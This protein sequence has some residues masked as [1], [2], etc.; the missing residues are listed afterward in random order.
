MQSRRSHPSW[1]SGTT[2]STALASRSLP[3]YE[4]NTKKQEGADTTTVVWRPTLLRFVPP[5][6]AA[7]VCMAQQHACSVHAALKT[8][9]GLLAC[10]MRP[11]NNPKTE[12]PCHPQTPHAPLR[13]YGRK[14]ELESLSDC[15]MNCWRTRQPATKRD[16]CLDA[17]SLLSANQP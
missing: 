9:S 1:C 6:L 3:C 5:W 13:P 17:L 4:T 12:R 14:R 11:R 8:S 2:A 15:N 10:I 7:S 16:L